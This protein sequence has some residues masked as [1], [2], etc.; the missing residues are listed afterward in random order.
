MR[1]CF[2]RCCGSVVTF[3]IVVACAVPRRC[4]VC[5][6]VLLFYELVFWMPL[7][8]KQQHCALLF[9]LLVCHCY[10]VCGSLCYSLAFFCALLALRVAVCALLV[11]LC[12]AVLCAAILCARI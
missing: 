3:W 11:C 12:V 1:C 4:L 7:H 10:F 2:V 5:G 8:C 6:F 9:L